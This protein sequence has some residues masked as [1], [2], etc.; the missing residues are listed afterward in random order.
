M[1]VAPRSF[2]RF[3]LQEY[4]DQLLKP[5]V[6]RVRFSEIHV[7]AT[8]KPCMA[9]FRRRP[10]EYYMQ[11]MWRFHTGTQGWSDIAQHATID[12]DG[13]IWAGRDLLRA[14]A[15]ATGFNDGDSDGV[16]PFMFEM[17]GNFDK[18]CEKLDGAQL[19]TAA[20]LCFAIMQLWQRGSKMIRFH[21]EFTTLKTCPGSG[22][23]KGWFVERVQ[24]LGR[25]IEPPKPVTPEPIKI[26]FNG[27]HDAWGSLIDGETWVYA[28][29]IGTTLGAAVGWN[30]DC[31]TVNGEALPTRVIGGRGFVTVRELAKAAGADIGWDGQTKTV[32]LTI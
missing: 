20:G 15:S 27:K 14:P 8:W 30:G 7:H 22:I 32:E 17:I 16:H 4:I 9:D 31:V 18:G 6:G 3:T 1:A 24:A 26:T 28:R 19:A 25:K 23:D 11:S 2:R 12:P 21:R 5:V 29:Q 13:Y 10:G